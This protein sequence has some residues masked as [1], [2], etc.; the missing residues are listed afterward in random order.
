MTLTA[1]QAKPRTRRA[2]DSAPRLR[3]V[4]L[5]IETTAAPRRRMIEGVARYM[6]EHE[7]WAVYLKPHAVELSLLDWLRDWEGDGII[8]AVRDEAVYEA[9]PRAIPMV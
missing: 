9:A 8:A 5:I 6:Q 4:A 2:P 7:P 1:T 3:R